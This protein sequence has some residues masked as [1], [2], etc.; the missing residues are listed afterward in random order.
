MIGKIIEVIVDGFDENTESFYGRGIADAPDV[1]G[2]VY[3]YQNGKNIKIG[4][5]INVKIKDFLDYDLV[6]DIV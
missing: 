2:R 3:I 4:S 6:G 5:I 1:D